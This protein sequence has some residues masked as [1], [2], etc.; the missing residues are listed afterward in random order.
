[1]VIDTVSAQYRNGIPQTHEGQVIYVAHK[2]NKWCGF[3]YTDVEI[4]TYSGDSH[5]VEFWEHV[6][7]DFG[8]TY[9]TY[10]L[11]ECNLFFNSGWIVKERVIDV[12]EIE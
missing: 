6:E 1:M 7:F 3:E 10:T 8:K 9:K 5:H 2:Y 4:L 11:K 12:I